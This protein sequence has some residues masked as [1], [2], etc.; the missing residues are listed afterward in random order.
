MY[1]LPSPHRSPMGPPPLPSTHLVRL[2]R[3]PARFDGCKQRR[4]VASLSSGEDRPRTCWGVIVAH[5]QSRGEAV[6]GRGRPARDRDTTVTDAAPAQYAGRTRAR[7]VQLPPEE[8]AL[9]RKETSPRGCPGAS[10]DICRRAWAEIQLVTDSAA[11]AQAPCPTAAS[12]SSRGRS[13]CTREGTWL[14]TKSLADGLTRR[15]SIA[16][17]AEGVMAMSG[18]SDASKGIMHARAA[19]AIT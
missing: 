17:V 7:T 6:A 15:V 9:T 13:A 8:R 14:N 1:V 3:R 5:S 19:A 16:N 4:H 18:I 10:R 12:S 11:P 2:L